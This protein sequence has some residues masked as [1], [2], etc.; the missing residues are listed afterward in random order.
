V[1]TPDGSD[2]AAAAP[3]PSPAAG[4]VAGSRST[5]DA[6]AEFS[7][8][9]VYCNTATLGL[10]PARTVRA[11]EDALEQWRSGRADAVAFDDAVERARAGYAGLVGVAPSAVAVGSQVSPLVGLV[12]ASLPAGSEVL[13]AEG[14]FTSVSFPF[15]A[16][17][18][19][20][21][22]VR[23]APLHGLA[24]AVGPE[25]TLVAVSAVQSADGALADLAAIRASTAE[26]G[27]RMLVDLTQAVGWLPVHAGDF[28]LTVC[29]GYK[30]LLAPRGTAF[31][32]V[33]EAA[34][35][36]VQPHAAGWYAGEDRWSSIYGTPLRLAAD[37]RR[38]D[39]SPAWHSWVGQAASLDLLTEVGPRAL[40]EHALGLAQR[41]RTGLGLPP[42]D[43]AIVSLRVLPEAARRLAE[44]D[45]VASMRAGRLRLSFHLVNDEADVDTAV[46]AL[47]DLIAR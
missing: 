41:C 19:R 10:P 45:V 1:S 37:A 24:D 2:P 27:A 18:G 16:Q 38:F 40:H 33:T 3:A 11:L 39:T 15:L 7:A 25:T 43:S 13:C 36:L 34:A 22:R 28:D 21:V 26:H 47:A 9:V 17:S 30:W 12:A 5:R 35:E 23:E 32:T 14:E 44:A 6:H 46:R 4:P 8:E 31:L 29:G 42:G 20:G